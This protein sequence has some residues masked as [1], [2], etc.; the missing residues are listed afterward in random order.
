MFIQGIRPNRIQRKR[1]V[2]TM[3]KFTIQATYLMPVYRHTVYEASDLTAACEAALLDDDWEA[4]KLDYESARETYLTGAWA[5]AT[6][7]VGPNLPIPPQYA[8]PTLDDFKRALGDYDFAVGSVSRERTEEAR[9]ALLALFT[10][11]LNQN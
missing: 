9:A 2:P 7:H 11:A 10:K 1:K 4:S 5:G 6:D 3:P 8:S